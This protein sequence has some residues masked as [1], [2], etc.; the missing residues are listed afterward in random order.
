MN[1]YQSGAQAKIANI[2]AKAAIL[3]TLSK[4][5]T[6]KIK[7]VIYQASKKTIGKAS[8]YLAIL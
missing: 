1:K 5:K 4:G 7:A 3:S 8:K 6:A 2:A